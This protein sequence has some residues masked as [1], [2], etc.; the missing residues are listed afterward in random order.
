MD[1]DRRNT[2]LRKQYKKLEYC[3]YECTGIPEHYCD[4]FESVKEVLGP[5]PCYCKE[6]LNH[7]L[8]KIKAGNLEYLTF[9]IVPV[10]LENNIDRIIL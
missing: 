9:P 5:K 6:T 4:I 1:Y 8:E 3:L 2:P 10:I 7:D